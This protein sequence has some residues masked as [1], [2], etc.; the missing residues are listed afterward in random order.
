MKIKQKENGNYK[1]TLNQTELNTLGILVALS[2]SSDVRNFA[3]Q[4]GI[5]NVLD[6]TSLYEMHCKLYPQV[7]N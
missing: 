6:A 3:T 2:K 1:L 7:K 5:Y 4:R